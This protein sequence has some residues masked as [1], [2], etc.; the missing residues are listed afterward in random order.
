M[1]IAMA[2]RMNAMTTVIETCHMVI[3]E[4]PAKVVKVLDQAAQQA[5]KS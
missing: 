3:L 4:E 1:Q 2:K 5:L